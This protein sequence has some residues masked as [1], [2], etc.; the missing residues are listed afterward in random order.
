MLRL[1]VPARRH[2][3]TSLLHT[4]SQNSTDYQKCTDSV[5]DVRVEDTR[6]RRTT[7]HGPLQPRLFHEISTI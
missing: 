6:E 1:T 2:M 7:V 4:G 3:Q 5:W